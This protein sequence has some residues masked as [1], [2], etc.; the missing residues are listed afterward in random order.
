MT[1]F[2]PIN[3]NFH[4]P[5]FTENAAEEQVTPLNY[6]YRLPV[7]GVHILWGKLASCSVASLNRACGAELAVKGK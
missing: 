6:L 7:C 1:I 4:Y 5:V 3:L 2:F